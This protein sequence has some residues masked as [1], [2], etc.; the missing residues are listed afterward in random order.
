MNLVSWYDSGNGT[1]GAVGGPFVDEAGDTMTGPLIVRIED[2][3]TGNTTENLVIGHNSSGTPTGGFGVGIRFQ[4]ESTTTENRDAALLESVWSLP[5]DASRTSSF[6]IWV[7]NVATAQRAFQAVGSTTVKIGFFGATPVFK[8]AATDD[9]KDGLVSLG[10]FTDSGATPLNLDGGALTAGAISG[11]TGTFSSTVSGVAG[12]FS[13]AVSGTTGSF[14]VSDAATATVTNVLTVAHNS[15]GTAA[16]GFGSGLLFQLE[17]STTD[18]QSAGLVVCEWN[19]ATHATRTGDLVLYAYNTTTAREGIRV[20]GG[21]VAAQI[22]FF[23]TTPAGQ[24]GAT[25][26]IK[27]ALTAYGL[28]TGTSATP[29][30]LDGGALTAGAVSGTTGTFS[31]TVSGVA[32]T[33]SGAVS[34]TTGTFSDAVSITVTDAV[35]NATS[36]VQTLSH[37]STGTPAAGFGTTVAYRLETTV[38]DRAAAQ[39][40][41]QWSTATDASRAARIIWWI[42]DFG[43]QWECLRIQGSGTAAMIGFLGAA[44]VVR[45]AV[46]GSRGGNAAL[47][48]FLAAMANLGLI[49]N[50]TTA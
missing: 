33:F 43:G 14:T 12:T 50:S 13:G 24:A 35:T 21:S 28:L 25:A 32:G 46:T 30:N 37:Q 22:G 42:N 17:S 2:A 29:L 11:T 16:A 41:V 1:G 7:Y 36:T 27:D 31:S 44:A 10:L 9:I 18:N 23:G 20:R 19:I 5:T 48:S 49:T 4:L 40:D 34:G 6:A 38:Q 3:G 45:P 26:D 47:A 15:T 39:M 8:P